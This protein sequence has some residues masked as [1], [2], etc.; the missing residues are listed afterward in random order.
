MPSM[1]PSQYAMLQRS[2]DGPF[3]RFEREDYLLELEADEPSSHQA[4]DGVEPED[5]VK[6]YGISRVYYSDVPLEDDSPNWHLILE[7]TS[8]DL[9]IY[10]IYPRAGHVRYGR[11][12]YG[13][14]KS[15]RITRPVRWPYSHPSAFHTT[16]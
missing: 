11:P 2:D 8:E 9:T 13:N 3:L 16:G 14:I 5:D 10:P 6:G 1:R 12:K 4:D 7:V 15:I